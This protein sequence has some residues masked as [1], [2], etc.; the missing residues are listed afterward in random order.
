MLD[1]AQCRSLLDEDA[2]ASDA[3]VL[4]LRNLLTALSE[5]LLDSLQRAPDGAEREAS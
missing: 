3:E 4:A 1:L 5:L 2:P